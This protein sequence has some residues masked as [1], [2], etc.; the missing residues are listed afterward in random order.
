MNNEKENMQLLLLHRMVRGKSILKHRDVVPSAQLEQKAYICYTE[1]EQSAMALR[2]H[3][4]PPD[5]R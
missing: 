5:S 3:E 2:D 4:L 1:T